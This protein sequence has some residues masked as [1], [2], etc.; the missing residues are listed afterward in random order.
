MK[1]HRVYFV[2]GMFG[3]GSLAG[4]DYFHHVRVALEQRFADA[5]VELVAEVVPTPPTSSLRH[6]ARMLAK[7]VRASASGEGPIHLV[8]HSTGGLD[9]SPRADSSRPS[10]HPRRREPGPELRAS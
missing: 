3:F 4:Y 2:P 6:R 5:G 7:A 10:P 8:G 1:T 9:V